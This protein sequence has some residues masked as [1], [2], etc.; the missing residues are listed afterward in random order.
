MW[1]KLPHRP[2]QFRCTEYSRITECI[3]YLSRDPWLDPDQQFRYRCQNSSLAP[4]STEQG[5]P[6]LPRIRPPSNGCQIPSGLVNSIPDC[7]VNVDLIPSA[8]GP[9]NSP[10]AMLC[11]IR[12]RPFTYQG[13]PPSSL[14]TLLLPPLTLHQATRSNSGPLMASKTSPPP[15]SGPCS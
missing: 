4:S 15:P 14:N 6:P 12:L 10:N 9:A 1:A 7:L 8:V 3:Y 2:E 13:S 5:L 11:L